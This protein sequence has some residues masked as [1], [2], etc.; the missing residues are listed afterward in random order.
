MIGQQATRR[1]RNYVT[2][3][4]LLFVS[5]GVGA[6]AAL[7]GDLRDYS[8]PSQRFQQPQTIPMQRE[9]ATITDPYFIFNEQFK[10]LTNE[11]RQQLIQ[12]YRQSAENADRNK[13]YQNVLYYQRLIR[14]LEDHQK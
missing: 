13:E 14:M 3:I 6:V 10:N 5:A 8:L 2:V 1:F 9:A 12:S 4:F 11:Q 7:G